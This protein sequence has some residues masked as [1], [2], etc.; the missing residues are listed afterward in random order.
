MGE[1]LCKQKSKQKDTQDFHGKRRW[2]RNYFP[3]EDPN[4]NSYFSWNFLSCPPADGF[5]LGA[6]FGASLPLFGVPSPLPPDW[7]LPLLDPSLFVSAA[8]FPP[9]L[10]NFSK[11]LGVFSLKYI[12]QWWS[13]FQILLWVGVFLFMMC[14]LRSTWM[15]TNRF[16]LH[17]P[18]LV[19]VFNFYTTVRVRFRLAEL[20]SKNSR[21]RKALAWR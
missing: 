13:K 21:L 4:L 19:N 3:P 15:T 17:H 12:L 5:S 7:L 16:T 14:K 18:W 10:K 8:D 9:G 2:K 1:T 20:L 11:P 6:S